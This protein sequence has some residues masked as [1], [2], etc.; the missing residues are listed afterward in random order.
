MEATV[1]M[2]TLNELIAEKEKQVEELDLRVVEQHEEEAKG[3]WVASIK[4]SDLKSFLS[5]AMKET[6]IATIASAKLEKKDN[7]MAWDSVSPESWNVA[8]WGFNAA[9]A[10]QQAKGK[11][12]IGSLE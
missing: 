10:E 6:A 12:F 4:V 9:L 2:K 5:S 1:A 8:S 3:E 7:Y 11:E